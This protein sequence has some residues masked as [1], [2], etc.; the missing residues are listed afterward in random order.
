MTSGGSGGSAPQNT[1]AP[2]GCQLPSLPSHAANGK[3]L[4]KWDLA[5]CPGRTRMFSL[6]Q[7][8][9]RN[10]SG[11]CSFGILS[12]TNLLFTRSR[13]NR[14]AQPQPINVI[15]N[16]VSSELETTFRVPS[17]IYQNIQSFSVSKKITTRTMRKCRNRKEN[18]D[19]LSTHLDVLLSCVLP[20]NGVLSLLT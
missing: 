5:S 4:L 7:E 3:Q 19:M 15:R 6:S 20:V 14:W 11:T 9:K 1:L 16:Q 12:V 17:R 8:E 18:T 2:A 13:K 10:K